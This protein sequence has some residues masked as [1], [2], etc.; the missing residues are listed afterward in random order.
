LEKEKLN[1]GPSQRALEREAISQQLSKQTPPLAVLEVIG[2]GHC[3]YRALA[4]QLRR[5][6]PD[7]HQWAKAPDAAHEEMRAV[8]ARALRERRDS[9]EPFAELVDGEDFA[10]YCSR[11]ERSADWG[12]ELELRALAD[13]LHARILVYRADSPA[14]LELGEDRR[15]GEPLRVTYHRHWYA[16][17]EH[18]NSAVLAES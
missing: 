18:Y 3:L 8:C 1:A 5:F 16:L 10:G 2:D 7:L 6:R 9:Y 14:P 4:D 15:G 17:G 12:G 13:E 11:V